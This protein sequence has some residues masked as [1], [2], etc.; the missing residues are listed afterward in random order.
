MKI[1]F[2]VSFISDSHLRRELLL[3]RNEVHYLYSQHDHC[4]FCCVLRKNLPILLGTAK[5]NI[6]KNQPHTRSGP[7]EKFSAMFLEEMFMLTTFRFKWIHLFKYNFINQRYSS[8][9]VMCE[10]QKKTSGRMYLICVLA[11]WGS[12]SEGKR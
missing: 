4:I 8:Y 12:E 5:K 7:D 3:R 6:T 11:G 2:W 1:T 10:E 9:S